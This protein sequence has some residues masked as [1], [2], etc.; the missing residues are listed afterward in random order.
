MTQNQYRDWCAGCRA[1]VAA[2]AGFLNGPHVLCARCAARGY[3]PA[4]L[5]HDT[6]R[7]GINARWRPELIAE[8]QAAHARGLEAWHE[9]LD[10]RFEDG[11]EAD[12]FANALVDA[13]MLPKGRS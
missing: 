9:W 11:Q 12:D 3:A 6:A 13:A 5:Q 10:T 4:Q 2:R 7:A 1:E 8:A